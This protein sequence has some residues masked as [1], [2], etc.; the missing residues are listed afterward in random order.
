MKSKLMRFG[1]VCAAATIA[2]ILLGGCTT[3]TPGDGK[4]VGVSLDPA[5]ASAADYLDAKAPGLGLGDRLRAYHAKTKLDRV[6]D[7][8]RIAWV[9]TDTTTGETV[10]LAV[11]REREAARAKLFRHEPRLEAATTA[12]TSAPPAGA[13]GG[14]VDDV[15]LADI[16]AALTPDQV[17]ELL[18][19]LGSR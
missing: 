14:M 2:M 13:D 10:P 17:A 3:M 6:P 9:V 15:T 4:V 7:G 19:L 18:K 1:A 8:Y 5:I 16:K 11:W 12:D